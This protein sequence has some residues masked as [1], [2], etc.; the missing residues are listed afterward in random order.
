MGNLED[1]NMLTIELLP[2][3]IAP[4]Y[5]PKE[6]KELA[7]KKVI[8]TEKGTEGD[9]PI[10]DFQLEDADGNRYFTMITGRLMNQLAAAMRGVN[11][12]NHGVEEP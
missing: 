11:M 3:K 8:V 5:N 4:R 1:T 7:I 9:L 6:V 12:R 10:V 2:G